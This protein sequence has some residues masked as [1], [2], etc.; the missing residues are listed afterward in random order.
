[1]RADGL[2][3]QW[4]DVDAVSGVDVRI[5]LF[6]PVPDQIHISLRLRARHAPFEPADDR[7]PEHATR[8]AQLIVRRQHTPY[9]RPFGKLES[10]R[11]YT[12]DHIRFAVERDGLV[13][14]AGIAAETPLP[15]AVAQ[16]DDFI[17]AWLFLFRGEASPARGIHAHQ[18]EEV[19]RHSD[20][21]NF[22]GFALASEVYTQAPN[23]GH[24]LK[25]FILIAPVLKIRVGRDVITDSLPTVV[26]PDHC[27]LFR[28]RIRQR[29]Q[30]H[31]VDD[32]E[33]RRVRANAQ[34]ERDDGDECK[35]GLL[36]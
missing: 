25:S 24:P 26:H 7:Q 3:D 11:H 28:L 18:L 14:N 1:D 2:L 36:H 4:H 13:Q 33:D 9:L 30:Q 35:T 16:N 20:G 34:A 23:P 8:C 5:L 6:E 22:F 27:Q 15:Q 17:L 32:A 29:A 12:Y 21:A 10:G 19:G 31:T